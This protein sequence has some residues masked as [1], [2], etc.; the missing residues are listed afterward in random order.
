M[1]QYIWG[2]GAELQLFSYTKHWEH[3][4]ASSP[5]VMHLFF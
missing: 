4:S 2:P 1:A 3:Y 5:D